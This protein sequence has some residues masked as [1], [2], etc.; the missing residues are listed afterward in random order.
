MVSAWLPSVC[1]SQAMVACR[2][3]KEPNSAGVRA[4][5]DSCGPTEPPLRLID[6]RTANAHAPDDQTVKILLVDDHQLFREGV[7]LLLR[8]LANDLELLE[9]A[10]CEE[11][12]EICTSHPDIDVVLLDL[13]LNGRPELGGL[14]EFRTRLPGVPVVV[15]SSSD[16]EPT[17]RRAIDLGAMGFIPKSSSSEIMLNALRLVL[18]KGIYLPATILSGGAGGSASR[19]AASFL[20]AASTGGTS[21]SV[22]PRDLGLTHRQAD[23]L[24]LV[25]QGKSVKLIC[26]ELSLG[27]GTVKGH[28]SAVLR[29]LN[30]TTRTQAI[31]AAYHL[32]L[33]LDAQPPHL[34]NRR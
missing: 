17:V 11:A 18:A 8:G 30:V 14:V 2:A 10:S 24:R 33:Q 27:E 21:G 20:R 13:N 26:R 4:R 31:V 25:L 7:A 34:P 28:V 1:P 16:D 29:A 9:A 32:G 19:Q 15:L 3:L 22:T 12:F 5:S 23:V 6:F